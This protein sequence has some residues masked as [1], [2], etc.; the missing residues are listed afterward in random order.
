MKVW[1]QTGQARRDKWR[2][3]MQKQPYS[4]RLTRSL[5]TR[6]L[7]G[8]FKQAWI[9]FWMLFVGTGPAG[10][11]AAWLVTWFA[12]PH[13][14]RW[15]LRFLNPKGF[16]APS[17]TLYGKDIS[18]GPNIFIDDYALICQNEDGGPINIGAKVAISRNAIIQTS[19]GGSVTVGEKT[20]IQPNCFFSAA[21]GSI[22]IGADVGVAPYCAFYPHDHGTAEGQPIGAQPLVVKGDIVVED[23]AWLGHGVTVLSGVRIGKG[24]VIGAGSTVANDVPDGAVAWGV[25]AKV[26]MKRRNSTQVMP[27]KETCVTGRANTGKGVL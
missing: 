2:M 15:A 11:L 4:A 25:P 1:L 12:P 17:A 26:F 9:R 19:R 6:G 8:L 20:R 10:R 7:L 14:E 3:T 27:L 18:L 13:Y 16:V 24:A 22:R 23:G 21:E 5:R